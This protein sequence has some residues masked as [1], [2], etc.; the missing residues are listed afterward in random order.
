MGRLAVLSAIHVTQQNMFFRASTLDA[1]TLIGM[2]QAEDRSFDLRLVKQNAHMNTPWLM[3][4]A[5]HF[6]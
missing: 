1:G 6:Q 2:P 4:G 3:A 5:A